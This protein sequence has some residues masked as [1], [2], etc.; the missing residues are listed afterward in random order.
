[1][2]KAD[3][4]TLKARKARHANDHR[5]LRAVEV[6]N[7]EQ[8]K[9]KGQRRSLR[10]VAYE[11]NV[12]Y[13]TLGR[14][15]E[16]SISLS[17]FNALK[18]KLTVAEEN[19]LVEFALG[20]SDQGFPLTHETLAN[21]A[22]ALLRRRMGSDFVEVG[23]NWSDRFIERHHDALQTHWSRP[24]DSKRARALNPEVVKHWFQLV[25]EHIVDEDIKEENVYGMDESGFPP[26]NEG[27]QKVIGR[28]HA[29]LQHKSG[30]A[31]RENVTAL[32]TICADGSCLKPTIIFK[33]K[34]IMAK[35]GENNSSEAS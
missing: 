20:A 1:M 12:N 32:V 5:M 15:A 6:Y 17:A 30:G 23:K 26:G 8:L 21:H 3:S 7:A 11:F 2:G 24:L 34:N 19:I 10:S 28:R 16:G 4:N 31:D 27:R 29:K 33:G 14:H 9:P 18:Q 22:N 35:W 13:R 25:K